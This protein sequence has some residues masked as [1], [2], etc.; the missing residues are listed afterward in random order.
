MH[1]DKFA[2]IDQLLTYLKIQLKAQEDDDDDDKKEAAAT[3]RTEEENL[4]GKYAKAIDDDV[5]GT[6]KLK[7][8]K[9]AGKKK[10]PAF[11]P[12]INSMVEF[13]KLKLSPPLTAADIPASIKDLEKKKD[14]LKKDKEAQ[15]A[16]HL[17]KKAAILAGKAPEEE[18]KTE[19]GADDEVKENGAKAEATTT[20]E[21]TA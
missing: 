21:A 13:S 18:E 10:A 11:S 4:I 12:D 17:A 16:K 14:D 5:Y 2:I 7:Q 19:G 1:S 3:P 15:F 20:V 6:K 9:K 8:K